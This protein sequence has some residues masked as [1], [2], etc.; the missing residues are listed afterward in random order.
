MLIVSEKFVENVVLAPAQESE[1]YKQAEKRFLAAID[2]LK[3]KEKLDVEAA[4]VNLDM[5]SAETAYKNGFHDG[6]RFILNAMAGR[7]VIEYE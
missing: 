3:T 1:Q 5:I 4:A 6:I 2:K 7:E